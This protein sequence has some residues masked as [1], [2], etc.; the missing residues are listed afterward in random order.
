MPNPA[1]PLGG[2]GNGY[3]A[4]GAELYSWRERAVISPGGGGVRSPP[5]VLL[6][7][8][9]LLSYNVTSVCECD[10]AAQSNASAR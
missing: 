2:G 7:L 5:P 10:S 8:C 4:D 9:V 6:Y 1:L 3:V